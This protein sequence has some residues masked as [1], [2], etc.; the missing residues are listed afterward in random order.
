M[1]EGELSRLLAV[2]R[3]RPLLEALTVRKGPRKG[4]QY[5]NVRPEIRERLEW[6]GWERVLTYKTFLL[7]GLRKAELSAVTVSQ[8]FLDSATPFI[9]LNAGEEK[10]REGSEIVLR[11]DL[12]TEL[13]EWLAH[14]LKRLQEEARRAAKP[15]PLQLPPKTL[16]FRVPDGLLRIFNRDLNA[17]GIAKQDERG[18]TLDLHA[19]RTTLSTLLNR[20]GVAPRTAQATMRHSDIRLTMAT[21][22][23]PKLLDVRGALDNLPAL[24]VSRGHE[25]MIEVTRA[26]GTEGLATS[27]L[28]PPLA[29]TA[30]FSGQIRSI[31]DKTMREEGRPDRQLSAEVQ[32]LSKERT[33]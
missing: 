19:M 23:D 13:A 27:S 10:N 11:D 14:C 32:D 30:G 17:A 5:A 18:R 3:E 21:Y 31:L 15:I 22:T 12:A 2:A 1:D 4:E 16:L 7:C 33:R 26:T 8:V 29:P 6:L 9:R 20:A 25:P 24:P 28:A